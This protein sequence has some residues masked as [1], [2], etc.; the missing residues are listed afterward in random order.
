ME[1]GKLRKKLKRWGN[2]LVAVFTSEDEE[3]YFLKEGNIVDISNILL[4]QNINKLSTIKSKKEIKE[5]IKNGTK[6]K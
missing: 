4:H 1:K 3:V 2:N 5:K 6:N